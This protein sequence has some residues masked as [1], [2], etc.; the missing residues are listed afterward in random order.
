MAFV[1]DVHADVVQNRRVLQP[2]A[3]AVG[4]AVNGA[5]L[6]EERDRQA[7]NLVCVLRPVVAAL[8]QLEHAAATDVGIPIRLDDLLPVA[9]DV[10]EDEPFAQ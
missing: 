4:Q 1:A 9:C 7:R 5:C 8:S 2:L 6:V 3:L 10:I